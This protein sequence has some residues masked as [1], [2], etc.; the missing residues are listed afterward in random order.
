MP[1]PPISRSE[2]ERSVREVERAL[3]EG[4]RPPG[5]TGKGLG[6]IARAAQRLGMS[7]G[8]LTSRLRA[9]QLQYGIMPDWSLY[10]AGPQPVVEIDTL[11]AAQANAVAQRRIAQLEAEIA[12]LQ[13]EI[14]RMKADA[15]HPDAIAHV[16]GLVRE[17][18]IDP[19]DWV[20]RPQRSDDTP[21]VPVCLWS[22][23]HIGETVDPAQVYGMNA[24][25]ERVAEERIRKLVERTIHLACDRMVNPHYPGIVIWLGGDMVSGWLHQE[26]VATDWC[27]PTVAAAWCVSR[28]RWALTQMRK[29]FGRVLVVCSPGNHGR[30]TQ[31]PMAKNSAIASYDHI[32][33]SQLVELFRNESNI[34]IC[35]AADGEGLIQ[36]AGTRFLMMHGHELG[37]SGGDGIIGALG[38]IMR[39]RTKVGRSQATVGRDFDVLCL[40]HFHQAI[41][42]PTAGVIVNG[43]LK[44][45]D[46]YARVRRLSYATAS[47]M[48]FFVHP[49]WGPIQPF[50]VFL[51]PRAMRKRVEFAEL[52][53]A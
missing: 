45:W 25:N 41:W 13:A 1:T 11:S 52:V 24:F 23:W 37:V 5:M 39:G 12:Q 20:L 49:T 38:P 8:T 18:K 10:N 2:A 53:E 28:L 48:L 51:Q 35:V 16:L 36:I 15:S 7:S 31:K 19:P 46:E 4:H 44:G 30:I 33:Y 3:R 34:R 9:I 47:Q 6:A 29:K 27:P 43:T 17:H 26:L 21:G 22:D 50:D 14:A 32:I 42:Q 40:G